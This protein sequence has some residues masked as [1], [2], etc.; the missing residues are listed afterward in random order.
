[1][2]DDL[3]LAASPPAGLVCDSLPLLLLSAPLL[4]TAR[5]CAIHVQQISQS[6][7]TDACDVSLPSSL[8]SA[9]FLF[10]PKSFHVLIFDSLLRDRTRNSSLARIFH[11]MS[12]PRGRFVKNSFCKEYLKQTI[13]NDKSS[14]DS[15]DSLKLEGTFRS[16][17]K[18]HVMCLRECLR[19]CAHKKRPHQ[20]INNFVLPL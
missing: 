12:R 13:F 4:I 16:L 14:R 5:L 1:M 7:R 20:Q 9:A 3:D 17:A 15:E 18:G 2:W 11:E 19:A 10:R 8:L 6:V